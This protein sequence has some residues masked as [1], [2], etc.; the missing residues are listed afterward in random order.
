M[1]GA[2]TQTELDRRLVHHGRIGLGK[3]YLRFRSQTD[4]CEQRFGPILTSHI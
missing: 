4:H 2:A 1:F 3:P